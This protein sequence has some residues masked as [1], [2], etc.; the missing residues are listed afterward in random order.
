MQQ[1][2][3]IILSV[4]ESPEPSMVGQQRAFSSSPISVGRAEK[5]DFILPDPSVSRNHAIIRIT[6]DYSRVFITDSSTYGTEVSG[7]KVPKGPGSGF[8]LT[9][10][11]I[12]KFGNTAVRFELKLKESVQSTIVAEVGKNPLDL[13]DASSGDDHDVQ[14][15]SDTEDTGVIDPKYAISPF[16]M[17]VIIVCVLLIVY[18]IFFD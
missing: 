13:V 8:T 9:S 14:V 16:Y 4:L 18:L 12:I 17:G 10:G 15:Q 5:N 11:D 1:D 6:N 3:T 2:W 7:K